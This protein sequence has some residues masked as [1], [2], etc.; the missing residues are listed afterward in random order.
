[1]PHG[2]VAGVAVG[3]V[4]DSRKSLGASG[5]HPPF[6][7][8]IYGYRGGQPAESIVLSE[9][10]VDDIDDGD[11]IIYTGQGGRDQQS[12]RQV[13][14]QVFERGNLGLAR[15]CEQGVPV[16]VTRRVPSGYRYDGLYLVESYW[17][18]TGSDG[19]RVY[20]FRLLAIDEDAAVLP[21]AMPTGNPA[22]ARVPRSTLRIVRESSVGRAVKRMH[23]HLCQVCG[24]T[25]LVPGGRYSEAAHIRPLGRPHNGPDTIDNV[26]CLCPNHHVLLDRGSIWI[27]AHNVVQPLGL[28]LR[29][30]VSH[31]LDPAN[32]T[33]HRTRVYHP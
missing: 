9:G 30:V 31:T 6:Q 10:Y 7:A 12:G 32:V 28:P 19:F 13:E 18:Q 3:Q 23:D 2:H 8:G 33:Y 26:L 16:R 5:V 22:P 20:R 29:I 21:R 11:E 4:F 1:M 25:L 17:H 27:D 24:E 15:S 14:D